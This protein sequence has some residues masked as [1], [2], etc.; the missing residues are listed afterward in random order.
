MRQ[1]LRRYLEGLD[2]YSTYL[3]PR[4][5]EAHKNSGKAGY[6]GVGMDV[7][8]EP[9][10]ALVCLPHPGSPAEK[11]GI[12]SGDRLVSVD[13]RQV[14]GLSLLAVGDLVRGPVGS[15]VSLVLRTP[16]GERRVRLQRR[17]LDNTAVSHSRRPGLLLVRVL[18]FD[19]ST[20]DLLRQALAQAKRGD[21][22]VIDLRS[23]R[24]GSLFAGVDAADLLLPLGKTIVTLR[25]R[26]E[27]KTYR[28]RQAPLKLEGPLFLWQDRYTASSA[29]L[30]IAA[31][32]QNQVARSVGTVSF[33]K[34]STQKV[35]PL[36]DGSA[37][38]LTDGQLLAPDGHTWNH[39]GLRPSLPLPGENPGLAQ[40]LAATTGPAPGPRVAACP[41]P[42]QRRGPGHLFEKGGPPAR[43]LGHQLLRL[44]GHAP[45]Q[46]PGR[47]GTDPGLC[48]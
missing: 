6:S 4:E 10:G 28:S 37:L 46:R 24:G 47:A 25:R 19:S 8:R 14:A 40:Y 21:K 44:P 42:G 29:E 23:C 9:S 32:V 27:S 36:Q 3:S 20:P 2:P 5:Y 38:V 34:A 13:G 17:A 18:R 35:F 16:Q 31:L 12:H 41:G 33:G 48:R 39:K 22:L 1:A 15:R 30:M 11:A 45:R 7:Y 26:E 43:C